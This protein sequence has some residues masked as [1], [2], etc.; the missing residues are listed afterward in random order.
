LSTSQP[1]FADLVAALPELWLVA[2][3]ENKIKGNKNSERAKEKP[4]KL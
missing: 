3:F 2:V 1:S 4:K